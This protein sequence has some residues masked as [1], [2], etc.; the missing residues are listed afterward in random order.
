[1]SPSSDWEDVPTATNDSE[2]VDVPT[3]TNDSEWVDLPDQKKQQVLLNDDWEDVQATAKQ[4]TGILSKLKKVG[5]EGIEFIKKGK[6]EITQRPL[7]SLVIAGK[8]VISAYGQ[9]V[10]MLTRH[11][12]DNLYGFQ[13]NATGD[14][15][16]NQSKQLESKLQGIDFDLYG[17]RYDIQKKL[18]SSLDLLNSP[19][20]DPEAKGEI[21]K[22]VDDLS[23]QVSLLNVDKD[24]YNQF[25]QYKEL[26][27]K[28][29][30]YKAIG[31]NIKNNHIKIANRFTT[32]RE[33]DT[34]AYA[35]GNGIGQ[36]TQ[37]VG[38]VKGLQAAG[39]G[40]KAAS[41]V[42]AVPVSLP[43][44][45][46]M[47]DKAIESGLPPE[48]ARIAGLTNFVT[49]AALEKV[50]LDSLLAPGSRSVFTGIARGMMTE[51]VQEGTQQILGENLV[52][53]TFID[54]NQ[55]LLEGVAENTII[56]AIIGGGAGG[57]NAKAENMLDIE[58]KNKVK[59]KLVA[60]ENI[61]PEQ[62]NAFVDRYV[63][64]LKEKVTQ[65]KDFLNEK[66]LDPNFKKLVKD[67]GKQQP[68]D[69]EIDKA[70][71]EIS[72]TGQIDF[73]NPEHVQ[74]EIVNINRAIKQIESTMSAET[75]S[76]IILPLLDKKTE[77]TRK[78]TEL[79]NK[80]GADLV[81]AEIG[82]IKAELKEQ[83]GNEISDAQAAEIM[84]E[85]LRDQTQSVKAL[86]QKQMSEGGKTIVTGGTQVQPERTV[87]GIP[88]QRR[89]E[90]K[91]VKRPTNV[92]YQS[93]AEKNLVEGYMEQ[94]G[95]KIPGSSEYTFLKAQTENNPELYKQSIVNA[96]EEIDSV[97]KSTEYKSLDEMK[98]YL[99]LKD[100]PIAQDP[101]VQNEFKNLESAVQVIESASSRIKAAEQKL[102]QPAQKTEVKDANI[103][104]ENIN[105]QPD[106]RT[107]EPA[108]AFFKEGSKV[109][110]KE[111]KRIPMSMVIRLAKNLNVTLKV[112]EDLGKALGSAQKGELTPIVKLKRAIFEGEFSKVT[113]EYVGGREYQILRDAEII[114]DNGIIDTKK[115]R[116]QLGVLK[117]N[118]DGLLS[119][120]EI[121]ALNKKL[122]LSK[123]YDDATQVIRHEIGHTISMI[124]GVE[125]DKSNLLNRALLELSEEGVY[126][127]GE[128]TKDAELRNE[129]K[130]LTEWWNPYDKKT[131]TKSY[132]AYRN[133]ASELYAEFL[134]VY[135][136]DPATA[137]QVAPKYTKI[138]EANIIKRPDIKSAL[139]ELDRIRNMN[140]SEYGDYLL[141]Q[142]EA[143]KRQAEEIVRRDLKGE[144]IK[145]KLKSF[146]D[147][148]IETAWA[149]DLNIR[150]EM[151]KAGEMENFFDFVGKKDTTKFREVMNSKRWIS[152]PYHLMHEYMLMFDQNNALDFVTK[153][154]SA[155]GLLLEAIRQIHDKNMNANDRDVQDY[156]K[157]YQAIKKK[158]SEKDFKKMLD[159]SEK[160]Y[161]FFDQNIIQKMQDYK[162]LTD[163][164]AAEI[165][166]KNAK[167]AYRSVAEREANRVS[168]IL[169]YS[170]KQTTGSSLKSAKGGFGET[171]NPAKASIELLAKLGYSIEIN[172]ANLA[173]VNWM[174]GV[175]DADALLDAKIDNSKGSPKAPN[176]DY[177][178][179]TIM[180]NGKPKHYY[181]LKKYY[182]EFHSSVS[183][184]SE[185]SPQMKLARH[186]AVFFRSTKTRFNLLFSIKEVFRNIFEVA[187]TI[188][189]AAIPNVGGSLGVSISDKWNFLKTLIY[190]GIPAARE[191]TYDPLFK[192]ELA[193]DAQMLNVIQPVKGA[194]FSPDG[195]EASELLQSN[196]ERLIKMYTHKRSSIMNPKQLAENLKN[197]K[198]ISEA[199]KSFAEVINPFLAISDFG[200]VVDRSYKIAFYKFLTKKGMSPEDAAVYAKRL[201]GN[202]DPT[203]G[204]SGRVGIGVVLDF[205]NPTAQGNAKA[206]F[207][208][209]K[210]T[211][212]KTDVAIRSWR[213]MTH[214][215]VI[216]AVVLPWYMKRIRGDDDDEDPS[217]F[218]QK[219]WMIFSWNGKEF[220]LPK[221]N[222]MQL[223]H[224][225]IWNALDTFYYGIRKKGDAAVRSFEDLIKTMI[226]STGMSP[227]NM[228]VVAETIFELQTNKDTFTGQEVYN[229]DASPDIRNTQIMKFIFNKFYSGVIPTKKTFGFISGK[230]GVR[231][232]VTL[233]QDLMEYKTAK[234]NI[235]VMTQQMIRDDKTPSEKRLN[236]IYEK[237]PDLRGDII[238]LKSIGMMKRELNNK[239]KDNKVMKDYAMNI[240][241]LFGRYGVAGNKKIKDI[242][243]KAK[244]DPALTPEDRSM[245]RRYIGIF[246][247]G[248]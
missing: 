165:R 82:Q 12:T 233:D 152:E 39:L 37:Q 217:E 224:A 238:K 101:E 38:I 155:F 25:T 84:R 135:L 151:V 59:E 34:F 51:G 36:I 120:D 161:K 247:G 231:E 206:L 111:I 40:L 179:V 22:Q 147:K 200:E 188:D 123:N 241:D 86:D 197:S 70:T 103:V 173:F 139:D 234:A 244:S 134:S 50:G 162:L 172:R 142:S 166:E 164:S 226:G 49:N 65:A 169:G 66:V 181:A 191:M 163:E 168:S 208:A 199:V 220:S 97:I 63:D 33:R 192:N 58:L 145:E 219:R 20:L 149:Q 81:H 112:K 176:T 246:Y 109:G 138:F 230:S 108:V 171:R 126:M 29:K 55:D 11:V 184:L 222:L 146:A 196:A 124:A 87:T 229:K 115:Y 6:E 236:S 158:Y 57:L 156:E 137:K 75:A 119:L 18:K 73:N 93:V 94:G 202:P 193:R 150:R 69:I 99:K 107:K 10:D 42:A 214:P 7:Q 61:P 223:Q 186:V 56:G 78:Y 245:M 27:N 19:N 113:P 106:K 67:F 1:M 232:D 240:L 44:A 88:S 43:S 45:T 190:E 121:E 189:S 31:N 80:V 131:A 178:L 104:R 133:S 221:D 235:T 48:K 211:K 243:E 128:I 17:Q 71:A 35:L 96:N 114:D 77:L 52:T 41:W 225:L 100:S 54:S 28:G 148:F 157:I 92:Q 76:Q 102:G 207:L 170:K 68:T 160:H 209:S 127:S 8:G 198:N 90:L 143:D 183:Q 153:D 5:K 26:E 210:G 212:S 182:R 91:G 89:A 175:S 2:W 53:K 16:L 32:D 195:K 125:V 85:M 218:K 136:N 239:A 203:Y 129:L 46:D 213:L 180:D 24:K 60:K 204:G 228:N 105:E 205:F 174:K 13:S 216:L 98:E 64:G 110:G 132:I 215:L 72:A 9:T 194:T 3:A 167:Y 144:P 154:D 187:R 74:V 122:V 248:N 14:A 118:L 83:T 140:E 159:M 95:I 130:K 185:L 227:D 30:L 242:F 79:V 141:E 177:E 116:G 23:S 21:Q 237:Y 201:A 15:Y 4:N 62:L 117:K 47:Y